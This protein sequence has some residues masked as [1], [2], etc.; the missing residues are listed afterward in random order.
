LILLQFDWVDLIEIEPMCLGE[1]EVPKHFPSRLTTIRTSGSPVVPQDE[2][3]GKSLVVA[4][5]TGSYQQPA[6]HALGVL[7]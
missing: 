7:R 2:V 6:L 3:F 1:K 4:P 5:P